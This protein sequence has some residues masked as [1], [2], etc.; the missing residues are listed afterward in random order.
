MENIQKLEEF[1]DWSNKL[2][3]FVKRPRQIAVREVNNATEVLTNKKG[4]SLTAEAGKHFV[5][6]NVKN[7]VAVD[8]YPMTREALAE[9][10]KSTGTTLEG[11]AVYEGRGIQAKV[12][13]SVEFYNAHLTLLNKFVDPT[14]MNTTSVANTTDPVFIENQVAT[15]EAGSYKYQDITRYG[16]IVLNF[17][18]DGYVYDV[19]PNDGCKYYFINDP[20]GLIDYIKRTA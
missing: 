10:W 3:R 14:W 16:W 13:V 2:P 9:N 1:V 4:E 11:M 7:G 19:Y 20:M 15:T 8:P 6:Y 5:R 17:N 18:K 12:L